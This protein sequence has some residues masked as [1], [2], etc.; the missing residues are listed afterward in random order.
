MLSYLL[1]FFGAFLL[2]LLLTP[3][4]KR[5]AIRLE[6]FD[7]PDEE[8]RVHQTPMPRLGGGALYVAFALGWGVA[9]WLDPA[10]LPLGKLLLAA[11]PIFVLGVWDDLRGVSE[12]LKLVIP[13]LSAVLLYWF[14]WRVTD[15]SLFPG[16]TLSLPAL[17]GLGLTVL[18]LVGMTNAYNLIDGLDGLAVGIGA[19]AM[20]AVLGCALLLGAREIALLAALL[21]GALVGFLPHNFHPAAIFLGDSGSLFLGF[22]MAALTLTG[23]A[24]EAGTASIAA[25]VILGL[26]IVEAVV[27]LLRRW[28]AGQPLLPGD[29]GHFHHKL[30]EQGLSQRRAVLRLYVVG[31]IFSGSGLL[32]LKAGKLLTMGILILL[33]G[34]IVW[35]VRSLPYTEFRSRAASQ[36]EQ[37]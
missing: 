36:R 8:R 24:A 18:W 22:V 21:L 1:A 26:L 6:A 3:L 11:T 33:V 4:V 14:G 25:P 5:Q 30:L 32:L 34:G 37:A 19:L 17:L 16:M 15:L 28:I 2:T 20:S 12:R 13:T 29:R 9:S 23:T 7:H 27:T 10:L 31:L 35:G